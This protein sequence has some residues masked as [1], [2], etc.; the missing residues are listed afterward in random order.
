MSARARVP[1]SPR[2]TLGLSFFPQF[3]T[4]LEK[5]FSLQ[6]SLTGCSAEGVSTDARPPFANVNFLKRKK[7]PSE[8]RGGIC[9]C[10]APSRS[11]TLTQCVQFSPT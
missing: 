9:E 5:S 10:F 6:T 7:K 4:Q 1:L 2:Q 11:A 8:I 3:P